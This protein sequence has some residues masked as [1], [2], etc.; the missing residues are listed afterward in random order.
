MFV[1][2]A[3][4][5]ELGRRIKQICEV[6]GM[7]YIHGDLKDPNHTIDITNLEFED[8]SVDVLFA[9]H[10]LN[11]VPDDRLAFTEVHRVLKPG[12]LAVLPV[13]I[14]AGITET[15][16]E[17]PSSGPEHRRALFKDDMMYRKY[18]SRDYLG[19]MA[20]VGFEPFAIRPDD[21]AKP[22]AV[23]WRLCDEWLQL[24]RRLRDKSVK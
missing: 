8:Q 10:V 9:C 24:G 4:E 11:M 3:P 13:P 16:E 1:H 14:H 12:G 15:L 17:K 23:K 7:Q 5:P 20:S 19:R 22:D 2:V 21:L 18:A 6:S